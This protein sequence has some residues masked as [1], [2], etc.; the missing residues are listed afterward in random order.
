MIGWNDIRDALHGWEQFLSFF[1]TSTVQHHLRPAGDL[2]GDFAEKLNRNHK[3]IAF[4]H[5]PG[6]AGGLLT[7]GD[8]LMYSNKLEPRQMEGMCESEL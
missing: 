3:V 1:G 6:S 4:R 7:K 5:T 2:F 8:G